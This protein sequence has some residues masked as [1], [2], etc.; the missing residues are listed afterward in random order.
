[1]KNLVTV[2]SIINLP[3]TPFSYTPTRSIYTR[4][5]RFEQTKKTIESIK[6]KIS[7][8]KILLIE[9]TDF[10]EE[11]NNY[12]S[13]NCDYILN[14]WDNKELHDKIFGLS[15]SLGEGTL[16][17]MALRFIISNDLKFDNFFKISGRYFLNDYFDFER[18]ENDKIVCVHINKSTL[19]V[20]TV[21]YKI[22]YKYINK[23]HDF[24]VANTNKMVECIGYET[25][26]AL[27]VNEFNEDE[28]SF[29]PK[30]GVEGNISV[31][32]HYYTA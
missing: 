17:I 5:E 1:M 10:T 27:F 14:L 26:M 2:N 24:L 16:T 12:F 29:N 7:D 18:F 30:L 4:E 32:N 11:E 20:S 31:S 23:F 22:P 3:N 8:C 25:L 15:K 9:C 19:F 13:N 28:I 21:L 6:E